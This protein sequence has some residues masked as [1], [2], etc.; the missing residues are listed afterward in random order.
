MKQIVFI[1]ATALAISCNSNNNETKQ[2]EQSGIYSKW[3][4]RSI[5]EEQV[6]GERPVYLEFTENNKINGF[7]GCNS[8]MGTFA[9][10]NG[11]EIKFDSLSTTRMLCDDREMTVE[12]K[13][14]K[15]LATADNFTINNGKMKLNTGKDSTLA[16]LHEMSSNEI[17]HT[18]WKLIR[19][20]ADTVKMVEGQEREQYLILR[21]DGSIAGFGG[22]NYF[23]GQYE[24][25]SKNHI[26][27]SENMAVTMRACPDLE[28]SEGA[29]LKIFGRADTYLV[30]GDTLNISTEDKMVLAVFEAVH[31]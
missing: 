31:F 21:G 13:V 11:N 5:D 29:Y 4:L 19:L 24:L 6:I 18:Y 7:I 28:S 26:S 17:L 20:G 9:I 30:N 10:E 23:N 12:S 25:S 2:E 1:I 15:L 8:L 3:E 27:F 16:T 14:L 22:C